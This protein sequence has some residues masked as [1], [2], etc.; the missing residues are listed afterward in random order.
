MQ[1]GRK[2]TC[3]KDQFRSDQQHKEKQDIKEME[4]VKEKDVFHKA[5][6]QKEND[7]KKEKKRKVS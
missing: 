6:R 3:K 5:A 7:E 1:N 2:G 4:D